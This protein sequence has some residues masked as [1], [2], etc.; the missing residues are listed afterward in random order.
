VTTE[1]EETPMTATLELDAS[2][3]AVS[4]VGAVHR[5]RQK[6]RSLLSALLADPLNETAWAA[7]RAGVCPEEEQ[8]MRSDIALLAT[9]AQSGGAGVGLGGSPRIPFPEEDPC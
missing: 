2:R 4:A 1:E 7:V 3:A 6:L 5:R 9:V 8:A